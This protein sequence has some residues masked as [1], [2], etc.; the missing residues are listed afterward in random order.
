MEE[1]YKL[2]NVQVYNSNGKTI[3]IVSMFE[4]LALKFGIILKT[5]LN[6][7]KICFLPFKKNG[8]FLFRLLPWCAHCIL[9][10]RL[11]KVHF[12]L[13]LKIVFSSIQGVLQEL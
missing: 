2:L 6:V 11:R 1:A 5:N 12:L 10:I 7:N 9:R 13:F 4:V 8:T 3:V